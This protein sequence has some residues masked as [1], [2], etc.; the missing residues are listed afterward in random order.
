LPTPAATMAERR[1]CVRRLMASDS[2]NTRCRYGVRISDCAVGRLFGDVC[3]MR[4][5][6][7]RSSTLYVSG[8][9]W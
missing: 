1:A 2:R 5:M 9:G 8:I 7:W 6:V 3:S 4:E